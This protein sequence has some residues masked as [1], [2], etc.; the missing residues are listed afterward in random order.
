M[1]EKVLGIHSSLPSLL[2]FA[3]DLSLSF[4]LL[5]PNPL[6]WPQALVLNFILAH[7]LFPL[8]PE[9]LGLNLSLTYC[10]A[11]WLWVN[12][13][14]SL[15]SSFLISKM[16]IIAVPLRGLLRGV[17]ELVFVKCLDQ[18]PTHGRR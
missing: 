8:E 4:C 1:P 3:I 18:H 6:T 5:V 16:R 11:T 12:V 15:L 14:T 17:D 2:T 10:P 7:G 9:C 13:L